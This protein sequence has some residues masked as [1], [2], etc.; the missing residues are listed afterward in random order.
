MK[1]RDVTAASSGGGSESEEGS[2]PSSGSDCPSS[3]QAVA[4]Q[5][6]MCMQKTFGARLRGVVLYGSEARG[7]AGPESDI[8]F[9]VLLDGPIVLGRDLWAAID[10]VYALELELDRPIHPIPVDVRSYEA[11]DFALYRNAKREGV[12]V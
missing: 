6:K 11:G 9:L 10:A 8:D 2:R 5:L 1:T 12:L 7:E 3:A 4:A